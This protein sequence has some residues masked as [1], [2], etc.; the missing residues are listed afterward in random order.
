MGIMEDNLEAAW[1]KGSQ[2][3][4]EITVLERQVNLFGNLHFCKAAPVIVNVLH[5]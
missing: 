1:E 3:V 5:V 2:E 4:V